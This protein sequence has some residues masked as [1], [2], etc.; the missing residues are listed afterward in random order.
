MVVLRWWI[1]RLK[2]VVSVERLRE[3]GSLGRIVKSRTIL[4]YGAKLVKVTIV[5]NIEQKIQIR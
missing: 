1:W 5:K 3:L 2:S 4:I